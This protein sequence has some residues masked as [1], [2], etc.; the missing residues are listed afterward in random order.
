MPFPRTAER[1]GKKS[2]NCLLTERFPVLS[3]GVRRP[4]ADHSWRKEGTREQR[5]GPVQPAVVHRVDGGAGPA[6]A[7][8]LPVPDTAEETPQGTV[9]PREA[10]LGA[11]CE[12]DVPAECLPPGGHPHGMSLKGPLSLALHWN[13]VTV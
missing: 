12:E 1:Q 3:P 13:Y 6:L 10:S 9:Y 8:R 11:S 4:G 7:G 5:H 2:P